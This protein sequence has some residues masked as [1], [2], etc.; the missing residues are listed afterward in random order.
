[1]QCACIAL[2]NNGILRG[3]RGLRRPSRNALV[4]LHRATG[5][6]V[7]VA[8]L[9]LKPPC[10]KSGSTA[11]QR[12]EDLGR[13]RNSADLLSLLRPCRARGVPAAE[14]LYRLAGMIQAD[15]RWLLI[16]YISPD[17]PVVPSARIDVA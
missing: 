9:S 4:A 17:A 2:H 10:C 7:A 5:C 11:V 13:C 1:M 14:R 3:A 15:G 6:E 12:V 16:Y 8:P